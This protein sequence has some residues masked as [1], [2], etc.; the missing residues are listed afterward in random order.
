VSRSLLS[1]CFE[2]GPVVIGRF[3]ADVTDANRSPRSNRTRCLQPP[4]GKGNAMQDKCRTTLLLFFVLLFGAKLTPAQETANDQQQEAMRKL[5]AKMDELKTQMAEIQSELDKMHGT[6]LPQTGSI[7]STPPKLPPSEQFTPQQQL[8]AAGTATQHHQTFAEDEEDAPRIYNAPLE[9]TYPG[10]FYLPG[11]NTM[12]RIDGFARTDFIYDP[13]VAGL[14]DSFLPSSIPIPAPSGSQFAGSIRGSRV[15]SDFRVP[16]GDLGTARAFVQI[17]FFG[18]NGS[19]APRLRHFYAQLDNILVGQTFSNFM[20]PDAFADT[21]DT[22]GSNAAISIR[23]PQVRYSLGLGKGWSAYFS[24]EQP[25]TNIN[26]EVNGTP[27]ES[28]T[29]APDGTIRFL[30]EGEDGHFQVAGVFR[31]LSVELPGEPKQSTFGW[32]VNASGG[33]ELFGRDNIVFQAAYGYGISRYVGDA[34]G[35]GLDVAPR[36]VTNPSL[37]ALPL[38]AGTGSYQHYWK[39]VLRSNLTF[40]FVQVQNTA[41]QLSDTYHK[42]IYTSGNLIWNPVGSLDLGAEFIWGWVQQKD[43]AEANAPRVQFT[44]RYRFV[45]LREEQ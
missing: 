37:R 33:V 45:K 8:Q 35:L 34:G 5:Q 12:L 13:T 15:S 2:S 11:T 16:A 3:A 38:F 42:S 1:G 14:A 43:G 22:Q 27:A 4:E 39:P 26:F 40:G 23:V 19:T 29:P 10:F 17:D 6:K 41:F 36:S 31:D 32:G 18:P 21:L 25:S 24:I 30:K 28:L 7:Q 20:D 9:P 44:A